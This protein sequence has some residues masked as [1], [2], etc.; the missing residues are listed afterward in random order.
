[1][2]AY[3]LHDRSPLSE[4]QR[5]V[6]EVDRWLAGARTVLQPSALSRLPVELL[7]MVFDG[8]QMQDVV[9]LAITCKRLLAVGARHVLAI[10]TQLHA[11]WCHNRLIL[12]G[13]DTSERASLPAGLYSDAEWHEIQPGPVHAP[14]LSYRSLIARYTAAL[15][16]QDVL[17]HMRVP[18]KLRAEKGMFDGYRPP[19]T[20]R[21]R[22]GPSDFRMFGVLWG[23]AG[24]AYAGGAQV[25]CNESKGEYVREDGLTDTGATLAHALLARIAWSTA[26]SVTVN[27]S[28][29]AR[30]EVGRG[31][32]AGDRFCVVTMDT[33][34][35]LGR[36][37][38]PWRDVT[39]AVDRL[40][41]HLWTDDNEPYTRTG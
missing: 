39:E 4:R 19:G 8:L 9:M 16:R 1:M 35:T 22:E 23:C 38:G 15:G 14:G 26:H 18:R 30:Q 33:L 5:R 11:P 2:S 31:P 3:T 27:C 6:R 40:L 17:L 20:A 34:P 37:V 29:E 7:D 21:R 13:D 12:L 10:L 28:E 24:L 32:W 36:G 41:V 25:L